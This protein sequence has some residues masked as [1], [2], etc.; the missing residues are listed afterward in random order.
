MPEFGIV[1]APLPGFLL[2]DIHFTGAFRAKPVCLFNRMPAWREYYLLY[3]RPGLHPGLQTWHPYGV[4]VMLYPLI[5]HINQTARRP[6]RTAGWCEGKCEEALFDLD[7]FWFF[8][9]LRQKRTERE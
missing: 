1:T 5:Q 2:F 9:V 6:G 8:F 3:Y 7:F 4:A